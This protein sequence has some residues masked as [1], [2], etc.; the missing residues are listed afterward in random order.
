MG[1]VAGL[2]RAARAVRLLTSLAVV[3]GVTGVVA[4]QQF[5]RSYGVP[6]VVTVQTV[7]VGDA[8]DEP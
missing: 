2:G 6:A 8:P 3:V 5:D 7:P 1:L 4:L